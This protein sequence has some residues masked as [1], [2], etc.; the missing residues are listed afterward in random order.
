MKMH[1]KTARR[2]VMFLIVLSFAFALVGLIALKPGTAANFYVM[3]AAFLLMLVAIFFMVVFC[4]CPWCDKRIF[5]GMMKVQ[6]CPHCKRD[7]DTGMKAK[8]KNARKR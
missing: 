6:V 3:M 7:I 5:S 2:V 8:G 1:F 4:R